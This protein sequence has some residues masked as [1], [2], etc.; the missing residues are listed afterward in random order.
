MR[1]VTPNINS[2]LEKLMNFGETYFNVQELESEFL[3][4]EYGIWN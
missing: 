2:V 1:G 3:T 4:Q